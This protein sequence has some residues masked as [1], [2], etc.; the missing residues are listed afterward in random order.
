MPDDS[1]TYHIGNQIFGESEIS[2]CRFS[3]AAPN[4]FSSWAT[5]VKESLDLFNDGK[6]NGLPPSFS[7][8]L[9]KMLRSMVE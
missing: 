1:L 5:A 6:S 4:Q 7:F 2:L 9:P 8:F 3:Q